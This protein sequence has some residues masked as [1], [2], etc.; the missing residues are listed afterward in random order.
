M[1]VLAFRSFLDTRQ[2][3]AT[4]RYWTSF[5]LAI[6]GCSQINRTMGRMHR[7]PRGGDASGIHSNL[8]PGMWSLIAPFIT[9]HSYVLLR[10]FYRAAIPTA[11]PSIN[12]G[13][14]NCFLLPPYITGR[15]DQEGKGDIHNVT[16]Y[17]RRV[18]LFGS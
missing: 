3:F 17:F 8:E 5:G 16:S 13:Q 7:M 10:N 15:T 12:H 1:L 18:G 6:P 14:L 11:R 9:E 2:Q 4:T